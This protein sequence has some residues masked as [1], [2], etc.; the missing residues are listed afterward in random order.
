MPEPKDK[1]PI[2]DV[3]VLATKIPAAPIEGQKQTVNFHCELGFWTTR[4][5]AEAEAKRRGLH[6]IELQSVENIPT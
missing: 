6:V 2:P 4:H 1:T 5:L 3:F